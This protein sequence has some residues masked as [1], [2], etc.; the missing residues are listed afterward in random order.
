MRGLAGLVAIGGARED[1]E[2]LS[3]LR[4]GHSA[5][6]KLAVLLGHDGRAPRIAADIRLDEPQELRSALGL[7]AGMG[8]EALAL[9]A[10]EHWGISFVDRLFGDFA[11]AIV[12]PRSSRLLLVRD[13]LGTRPLAFAR[14][15]S[16]VAFGSDP[17]AIAQLDRVDG[18]VDE[19]AMLA[20]ILD[21]TQAIRTPFRGIH[22]VRAGHLVEV[23][24]DNGTARSR[25]WWSPDPTTLHLR[26]DAEYAERFR[27]V[28]ERAVLNRLPATGPVGTDLSGGLDSSSVT[29]V[30]AHLLGGSE[31]VAVGTDF[32]DPRWN[33]GSRDEGAFRRE[34]AHKAQVSLIELPAGDAIGPGS[35]DSMIRTQGGPYAGLLLQM[36]AARYRA[37]AGSGASDVRAPR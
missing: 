20:A 13:H 6:S 17:A 28:F 2:L 29:A 33:G 8:E 5:R 9:A 11:L 12:D 15:G 10:Y 23:D 4:S 7:S 37:V 34:V 24:L 26:R 21:S 16:Y 27:A 22:R 31:V 32:S 36:A 25:R 18:E 3:Q 19:F 14:T 1:P 30:A 35:A